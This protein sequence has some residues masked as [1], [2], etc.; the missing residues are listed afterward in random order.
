MSERQLF[1]SQVDDFMEHHPQSPLDLK[2]R[3]N[4]DGLTYFADNEDLSIVV[5][6]EPFDDNEPLIEMETSTG[7]KRPYRR[8]GRFTFTV[9]GEDASLTIYSDAHGTDFFLPFRDATS[10]KTSY[11]AG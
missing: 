9:N 6:V 7:D 2:Q 1:R 11:G 4:F 10:G 5:Q 3:D 8:Y